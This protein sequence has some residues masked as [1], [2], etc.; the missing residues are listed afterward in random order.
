MQIKLS[1]DTSSKN[2][3]HDLEEA[4]A[5]LDAINIAARDTSTK[6]WM[7]DEDAKKDMHL[8]MERKSKEMGWPP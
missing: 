7:E 1:L 5:L 3:R 6:K 2:L 4:K 8:E